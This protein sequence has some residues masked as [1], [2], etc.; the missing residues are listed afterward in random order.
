MAP[1]SAFCWDQVGRLVA[2]RSPAAAIAIARLRLRLK[3]GLR[4]RLSTEI[5]SVR[6][7][8]GCDGTGDELGRRW[9]DEVAKRGGR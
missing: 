6:F 3:L 4:L 8:R 7:A 5:W 2:C 1:C 9:D